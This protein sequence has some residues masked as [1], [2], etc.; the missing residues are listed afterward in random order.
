L[1]LTDYFARII[2]VG[3][4]AGCTHFPENAP[5]QSAQPERGHRYQ[6]F[7][8]AANADRLHVILTFSGGGTRA[9]AFSYG[10]MKQ[11]RATRIEHEGRSISL[12]DEVDVISAVSGGSFTAAYYAAFGDD[13]FTTF[14]DRVLKRDLQKALFWHTLIPWNLIRTL[15]STFGTTDLAAE[16]YDHHFFNHLTYNH[17]I[18]KGLR[19]FIILNATDLTLG[20]PFSFTQSQFDLLSSDLGSVSL[21]RAVA[22]SSAAPVVFSP[23]T[24]HNHGNGTAVAEPPWVADALKDR[25][26]PDSDYFQQARQARFYSQAKDHSYVH[27][28]D[29]GIADNLGVRPI[30]SA[31]TNTK[32]DWS[33]LHLLNQKRVKRVVIITV[34]ALH[35]PNTTWG[36]DPETPGGVSMV[37]DDVTGLMNN[38]T[39]E[40][41]ALLQA[42]IEDMRPHYEVEFQV[43]EVSFEQIQ[44]DEEREFFETLPMSLTLPAETVDRLVQKAAQLLTDSPEYQSLVAELHGAVNPIAQ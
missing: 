10:I 40:T 32:D 39:L 15:S 12:L 23:V 34:N 5:L 19:P 42:R 35:E 41:S 9:A 21:G 31:L 20:L 26:H 2:L 14:E 29:G 44:E 13:L 16:F 36:K 17:L 28:V 37:L 43:I 4:L 3:L 11:L 18:E 27:L 1:K 8:P 6:N 38:A 30:L 24:F 7:S 22:A 33:I 25:H